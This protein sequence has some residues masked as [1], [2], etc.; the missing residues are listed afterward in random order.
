MNVGTDLGFYVWIAMSMPTL[1]AMTA[2]F[3]MINIMRD[4]HKRG[5]K[6]LF[7]KAKWGAVVTFI[8][9]IF[10]TWATFGAFGHGLEANIT[11]TEDDGVNVINDSAPE[12]KPREEIEKE[13]EESKSELLKQV[14]DHAWGK[15]EEDDFNKYLD[16]VLKR[17][18]S[19][20]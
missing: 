20:K 17:K 16:E 12:E 10:V 1:I 7:N 14:Q 4:A 11:P 15:G 5:N 9:V 3:F 8:V 6:K 19:K 2:F 18:T 13:A